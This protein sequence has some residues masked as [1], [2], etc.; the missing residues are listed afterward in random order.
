MSACPDNI[1]EIGDVVFHVRRL[2]PKAALGGL[3][4][5]GKVLLP[6]LAEAHTAGAGQVGNAMQKAVEGLDCLPELLDLF[7]GVSRFTREGRP[8]PTELKPFIDDVFE[9][10]PEWMVQFLVAC[11]KHEYA[12]FFS[13]NAP[14]AG[15]LGALAAKA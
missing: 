4:L 1:V 9:G 5:V 15:M 10:H 14:M 8:N 2:K 12:G 3:K 13:G 11:V 6:A 7:V